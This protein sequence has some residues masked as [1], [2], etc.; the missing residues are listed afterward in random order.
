[1]ATRVTVEEEK[2]LRT[3]GLMLP[4]DAWDSAVRF[5]VGERERVA[6]QTEAGGFLHAQSATQA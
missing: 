6:F 5:F 1:M 3:G 4:V 2:N